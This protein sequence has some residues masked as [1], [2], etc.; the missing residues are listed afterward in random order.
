[1]LDPIYLTITN[2]PKQA[3]RRISLTGDRPDTLLLPVCGG[4]DRPRPEPYVLKSP[5]G[6]EMYLSVP[7]QPGPAVGFDPAGFA[8]CGWTGQYRLDRIGLVRGDTTATARGTAQPILVTTAEREAA[9][10]PALEKFPGA[11]LDLSRI[12]KQKPLFGRLI[13][14]DQH[15]VWVMRTVARGTT[16]DIFGPDGRW[17][18]SASTDLELEGY[19]PILIQG[20]RLF[21]V[22]KD[23]D[24]LPYVIRFRIDR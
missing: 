10:A 24:D 7:F 20:D 22:T 6:M 13:V 11:R 9:I 19:L 5:D 14:D 8:W 18:A 17:L 15:R 12:P 1:V 23:Q 16:F 3:V 2:P 21:A 4:M